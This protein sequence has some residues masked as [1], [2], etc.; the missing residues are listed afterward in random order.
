MRSRLHAAA[1]GASL[2]LSLGLHAAAQSQPPSFRSG[3]DLV[4][5]SVTVMDAGKYLTDL[6]QAEFTVFEDGVKQELTFFTRTNLPVA[7]SILL[8]SSASMEERMPIA[9]AAAIGFAHR[10]RP[11]DLGEIVDFDSKVDITQGFT[12]DPKLLEAAIKRTNPGGSTALYNALYISLKELKKVP[13]KSTDEIRRQAIVILSDGEDTSSLVSFDEVLDLAKRS[14]TAIYTIGLRNR[15]S[16]N[17]SRGFKEAEFVLKQLAQETGGR[18][19]FPSR[20]EELPAVYD[21]ISEELSSQY[22]MGYSSRN[23]KRDGLWRRVVVRVTRPNSTARAKLGYYA[24]T[25]H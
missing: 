19:F 7:L 22:L 17:A 20:A 6:S 23:P 15:E 14:E 16:I 11:Q 3:V 21:Q 5:L 13:T 25:V 18:A 8:D 4:S 10:L 2:V 12:N 9:Q 1:A 24:P